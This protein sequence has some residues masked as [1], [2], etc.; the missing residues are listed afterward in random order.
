[1]RAI[2]IIA[3]PCADPLLRHG[4]IQACCELAEVLDLRSAKAICL[5]MGRIIEV[6]A[7]PLRRQMA[8][9]LISLMT[10]MLDSDD[11]EL[12]I[13]IL[14]IL[15]VLHQGEPEHYTTLFAEAGLHESLAALCDSEDGNV[16]RI[17]DETL[18]LF[19]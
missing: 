12:V 3:I 6:A 2:D 13:A 8:R 16:A 18:R 5:T 4:V 7:I 19:Q 17:A 14:Q 9:C 15:Q 11:S 1:L 10:R